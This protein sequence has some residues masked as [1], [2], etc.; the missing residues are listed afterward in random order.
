MMYVELKHLMLRHHQLIREAQRLHD[1]RQQPE[2][3]R[4][5]RRRERRLRRLYAAHP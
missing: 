3:P 5:H 2:N 1:L 4:A